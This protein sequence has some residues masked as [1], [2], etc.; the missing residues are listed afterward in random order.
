MR[1]YLANA[2]SHLSDWFRPKA[3]PAVLTGGQWS[4]GSYI[5]SYRRNRTPTPNEILAELKNTAWACASLNASVCAS[6]PPRLYVTTQTNQT[7]PK[8]LTK[9][10]PAATEKRLRSTP[11]LSVHTRSAARL[12]EVTDHPLLDLL[13]K[14]NPVH[15]AFDI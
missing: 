13:V 3:M 12:E 5:D 11:H 2:L 9:S 14:V 15:N 6:H 10:L 8:C 4:G 7:R 1:N